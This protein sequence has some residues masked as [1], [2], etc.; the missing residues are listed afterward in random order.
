MRPVYR[1][2]EGLFPYATAKQREK[3]EAINAHKSERAAAR[4]LGVNFTAV[5]NALAAVKRKAALQGY[6]P[7]HDMTRTVPEPFVTKG[8]ST[9]YNKD[10]KPTGQ[11]VKSQLAQEQ[12]NEMVKA[13]IGEFVAD[14]PHLPVAPAPLDFQSDIIPWIQIGDAHI[15]MLAHAAETTE[16]F[17]LKIAETELCAAIAQLIDEMP[18]CER[19]VVND[20]G[21]A[22]HYDNLAAVTAASGHPLDADGR[23]PKML[24]VYSRTM[25]FIVER[26]LT[27]CKHLD[28]IV[29]QG[30]HSRINDFWIREMLTVAYAHTGRV[31]VLDNDNVFIGY[32]MGNT[33]VMV[34]HSDKC[35]PARLVGVLTSDFRKDFGE[36]EFHYIDIGHVHHHFAS[37]EHPSVLIESWNHL[38]AN[39]KWAHEAGYRSRKAI[40]VVLRSR[41][42]GDVGR[43]VLPI[44]EI[45]GRLARAR[46]VA[47][48]VPK[49]AYAV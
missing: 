38:A 10:G 36:T 20:L 44:E 1:V 12:Y 27:K 23:H 35:P 48:P 7:E 42:Y 25:R 24:R 6:S 15:G 11:W 29:N 37:K 33:L 39:D 8:V 49:T 45:R 28:V 22:T 47:L 32:R 9:Y 43:R 21:D 16:N 5:R 31:H 2:D 3:L 19:I 14:V 26:C 34:H 13:A 18:N 4:A 46:G 17:D 30:N 41:T 40:T